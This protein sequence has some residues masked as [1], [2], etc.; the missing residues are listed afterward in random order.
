M[1]ARIG[2]RKARIGLRPFLVAGSGI[3]RTN[4]VGF[5][6]LLHTKGDAEGG[7]KTDCEVL[8]DIKIVGQL[9]SHPRTGM[10][11]IGREALSGQGRGVLIEAGIG[12]IF[13]ADLD[14]VLAV[15]RAQINIPAAYGAFDASG[16]AIIVFDDPLTRREAEG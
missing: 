9:R 14:T 1:L 5:L 8:T 10:E 13:N 7:R 4:L 16:E 2:Q 6:T 12:G 11:R 3:T 15:G